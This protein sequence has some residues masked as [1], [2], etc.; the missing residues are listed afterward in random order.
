MK[1]WMS[2]YFHKLFFILKVIALKLIIIRILAVTKRKAQLI[3]IQKSPLYR[4]VPQIEIDPPMKLLFIPGVKGLNPGFV[5]FVS[6]G[7]TALAFKLEDSSGLDSK[8]ASYAV[9]HDISVYKY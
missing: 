8:L 6:A 3:L 5:V 1:I 2:S 7:W 4:A 9:D